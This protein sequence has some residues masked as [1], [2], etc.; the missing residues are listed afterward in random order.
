MLVSKF[1]LIR[2][3]IELFTI[4]AQL[5]ETKNE[6]GICRFS[7]NIIVNIHTGEKKVL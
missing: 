6:M 3:E 1:T 5:S 2:I 7:F 4:I